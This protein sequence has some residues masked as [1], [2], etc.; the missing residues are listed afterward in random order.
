MQ[1]LRLAIRFTVLLAYSEG[2]LHGLNEMLHNRAYDQ[3]VY[4]C[5]D[6]QA[7]AARLTKLARGAY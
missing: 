2:K 5:K 6:F 7:F 4:D 1:G 3:I